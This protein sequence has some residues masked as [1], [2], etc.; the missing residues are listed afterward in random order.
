MPISDGLGKELI[1]KLDTSMQVSKERGE[2]GRGSREEERWRR[3][4]KK[5]ERTI[6]RG[7]ETGTLPLLLSDLWHVVHRYPWSGDDQTSEKLP[8]HVESHTHRA[9]SVSEGEEED[10]RGERK[11]IDLPTP[12]FDVRSLLFSHLIVFFFSC[13]YFPMNTAAYQ[14]NET[15]RLTVVGERS[16]GLKILQ[17]IIRVTHNSDEGMGSL[18]EGSME[19]MLQRRLLHDD[20]KGV[21][22]PLNETVMS[23]TL[24]NIFPLLNLHL[25]TCE[26]L[27]VCSGEC[28]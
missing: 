27:S 26:K 21:G 1:A 24:H 28:S 6:E 8:T 25:G 5:E 15:L 7:N 4:K 22:E 12:L 14:Q 23:N 20:H 16:R 19:F 11:R 13:N 17:D 10:E 2:E 18:E 9:S 3:E